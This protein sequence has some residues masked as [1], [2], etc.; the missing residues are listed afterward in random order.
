MSIQLERN[1]CEYPLP[2]YVCGAQRGRELSR[3]APP[4]DGGK[5][6]SE[7]NGERARGAA[8]LPARLGHRRRVKPDGFVSRNASYAYT[9]AG[10]VATTKRE[11]PGKKAAAVRCRGQ[12][13][14]LRRQWPSPLP[15]RRCLTA[16]LPESGT[17]I[18]LFFGEPVAGRR[19]KMGGGCC[20]WVMGGACVRV[21]RA[22]VA[23]RPLRVPKLRR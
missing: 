11:V 18:G 12:S 2:A 6:S 8:G 9:H 3:E 5:Y 7:A 21:S 23:E 22:A 1:I 4:G 17:L 13:Y 10:L 16:C 20:L 14:V 15:P 19:R